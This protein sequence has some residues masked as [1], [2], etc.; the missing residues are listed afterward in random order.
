MC[1]TVGQRVA[2]RGCW[3]PAKKENPVLPENEPQS[4]HNSFWSTS[5]H[6]FLGIRT[7]NENFVVRR[8]NK[9]RRSTEQ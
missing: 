1:E 6:V 2:G 9:R 4:D 5:S 7:W 3:H 8:Y